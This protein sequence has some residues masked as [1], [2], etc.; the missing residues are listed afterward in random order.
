MERRGHRVEGRGHRVEGRGHRVEGGSGCD[1][2]CVP[3]SCS[4]AASSR[5][6]SSS[7]DSSGSVLRCVWTCATGRSETQ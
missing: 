2:L 1:V 6:M 4:R 7:L 3:Y 5:Q